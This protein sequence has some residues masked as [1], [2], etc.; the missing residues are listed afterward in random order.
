MN[1]QFEQQNALRSHEMDMIDF[2]VRFGRLIG[3]Q[4]SVCEIYGLL[5]ASSRPLS[6]E[7]ISQRLSMS[8]GSASQ[9]LKI[10]RGL[11]GVSVVYLPAQRKDHYQAELDFRSIVTK[12]LEEEIRP[13]LTVAEERFSRI[14]EV[15]KVLDSS[16]KKLIE[17]RIKV[18]RKLN[19]RAKQIVPAISKILSL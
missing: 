19:R 13:F 12:F 6:M 18:F 5:L 7:D 1:R 11:N 3:L 16:E 17:D 8:M 14:E 2:V 15:A 4:K 9:G 10:L